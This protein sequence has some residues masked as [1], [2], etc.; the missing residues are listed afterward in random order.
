MS[1]PLTQTLIAQKAKTEA[2]YSIK[3]LNLWGNDLDDISIIERLTNVEVLPLS[4]IGLLLLL[5]LQN[6]RI[7][8]NLSQNCNSYNNYLQL[9]VLW[10]QENSIADHPNFRDAVICN[11]STL[12][13]LDDV[14]FSQQDR[15]N[16]QQEITY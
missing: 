7:Q 3:S 16:A 10:L 5:I 14:V 15:A 8:K 9:K 1:K 6:A 13:K 12:E 2:L 4:L 11:S